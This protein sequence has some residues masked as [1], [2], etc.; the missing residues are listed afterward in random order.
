MQARQDELR[1]KSGHAQKLLFAT[2]LLCQKLVQ[3]RKDE[4]MRKHGHVKTTS[5]VTV[6]LGRT[7]ARKDEPMRKS[8]HAKKCHMLRFD[9]PKASKNRRAEEE[10]RTRPNV[11]TCHGV[12]LPKA[13]KKSNAKPSNAKPSQAESSIA[14][15][16]QAQH[17]FA[18]QPHVIA[19]RRHR[20]ARADELRRNPGHAQT[21]SHGTVLL[22][23]RQARK[24]ELRRIPGHAQNVSSFMVSLLVACLWRAQPVT[25]DSCLE[26][27]QFV[28]RSPLAIPTRS[29]SPTRL[30]MSI[31]IATEVR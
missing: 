1:R 8:E 12:V 17:R 30:H 16:S 22:F 7:Q 20:Q 29:L 25:C 24:D 10:F 4:L 5:H 9:L 14:K 2:A 18:N 28:L 19:L 11:V 21:L 31:H 26:C 23:K 13:S 27:P 15:Q 6:L 3:A